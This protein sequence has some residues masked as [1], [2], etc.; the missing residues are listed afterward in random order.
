MVNNR[1]YHIIGAGIAG[2]YAAKLLKEKDPL[3]SIVVY[4]AAQKIGGRCGSFFDSDL[5]CSCDNATHV[6][7]SCNKKARNLLG[8]NRFI[9]KIRFWDLRKYSFTPSFL[10]LPQVNS[11]IF[12]T[13]QP[14]W[15]SF[16]YVLLKLFPFFNLKAYFSTGDLQES[17]CD[18]LL[19]YVDDIHYGCVWQNFKTD[20][21]HISELIFSNKTISPAPQDI[22]ISAIDSY[23]YNHIMSGFD[24]NYNPIC[25]VI[26][27]TSMTLT[28]PGNLRMLGLKNAVSHWLFCSSNYTSVTISHFNNSVEPSFLWNEICQIRH[29]NAA[30]L[31]SYKVM[32]FPLATIAQNRQNNQMRPISCRTAYDN[33]FICGDWT[34]K[35]QPCCIETALNSAVRLAQAISKN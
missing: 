17:L 26:F 29:Y 31:P 23:H 9:H 13:T 14:S 22:I 2:L 24:F 21:K 3:S 12:N 30:F 11:A 20:G 8:K 16:L 28:L 6:V 34:M 27:R 25:N 18:P 15:R 35:N 1:T 10:C 32:T 33:L 5:N 7:L 19:S 4:E